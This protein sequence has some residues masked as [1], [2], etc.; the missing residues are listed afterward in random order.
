MPSGEKIADAYVQ[1]EADLSNVP[2][3]MNKLSA[4]IAQKILDIQKKT[5]AQLA[6]NQLEMKIAVNAGDFRE[7]TRLTTANTQLQ[8]TMDRVN[9]AALNQAAALAAM[10]GAANRAAAA[11]QNLGAAAARSGR[12]LQQGSMTGAMGLLVLSQTIDD[13]QYGRFCRLA[14]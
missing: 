10:G 9:Q 1:I 2:A 3:N 14:A 13:M 8:A 4:T 6:R 5:A 12:S 7:I 11:H